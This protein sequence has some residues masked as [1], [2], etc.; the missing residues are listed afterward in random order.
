MYY[1]ISNYC[2]VSDKV[3][4]FETIANIVKTFKVYNVHYGNT[5][6][7][8]VFTN[9]KERSKVL[10]FLKKQYKDFLYV[11]TDKIYNVTARKNL[12][13]LIVSRKSILYSTLSK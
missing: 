1:D 10:S 2:I 4:F 7:D 12:N 8:I 3:E 11:T 5:T 9:K 13:S 6:C